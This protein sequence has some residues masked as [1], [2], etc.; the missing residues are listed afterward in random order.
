MDEFIYNIIQF[1]KIARESKTDNEN[2]SANIR[3]P[4]IYY[5]RTHIKQ[6]AWLQH[7][8]HALPLCLPYFKNIDRKQQITG[9]V[10]G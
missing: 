6:T 7:Y 9:S 4:H 5:L 8:N 10:S 1:V 3:K 2:N